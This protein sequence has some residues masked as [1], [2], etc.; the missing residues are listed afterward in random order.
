MNA[1]ERGSLHAQHKAP[2][3]GSRRGALVVRG[4]DPRHP[5]SSAAALAVRVPVYVPVPAD[6][7]RPRLVAAPPTVPPAVVVVPAAVP[8]VEPPV[9][10][11][12]PDALVERSTVPAV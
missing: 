12:V 5:R 6:D 9:L 3:P 1:N 7:P 11:P 4:T 8:A 2:L 10:T